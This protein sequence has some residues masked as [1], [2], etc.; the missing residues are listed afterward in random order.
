MEF[1]D[2]NNGKFPRVQNDEAKV[3]QEASNTLV[4][5]IKVDANYALV[6]ETTFYNPTTSLNANTL[7]LLVK[8]KMRD[9]AGNLVEPM[10][11]KVYINQIDGTR[12]INFVNIG[13]PGYIESIHVNLVG[14]NSNQ[15]IRRGQLFIVGY[16]QNNSQL[17]TG[18]SRIT[19]LLFC[20]YFETGH[21]L[22]FPGNAFESSLSE[23]V[24]TQSLNGVD[25]IGEN[26]VYTSPANAFLELQTISFRL[27]AEAAIANRN[28]ILNIQDPSPVDI[29]SIQSYK[30]QT[31]GTIVYYSYA[32]AAQD[33][34][35]LANTVVTQNI[36]RILLPP[37]STIQSQL[38]NLQAGDMF[39]NILIV[40][41]VFLTINAQN[42][43]GYGAEQLSYPQGNA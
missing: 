26:F 4:S 15:V 24:I 13:R 7:W 32:N 1:A 31:A 30:V 22:N 6:F 3:L 21:S 17:T 2:L 10:S 19:N 8:V 9:L 28:M 37:S 42:G 36:P 34:E 23:P 27:V 20:N 41:K 43:I 18:S 12:E 40:A 16:L 35:A 38:T 33:S 25:T 29:F 11:T 5:L 39:E 14:T